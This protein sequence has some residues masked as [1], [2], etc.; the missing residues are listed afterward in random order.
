[1][2]TIGRGPGFNPGWRRLLSALSSRPRRLYAV[3][4]GCDPH[5]QTPNPLEAL[6]LQPHTSNPIARG[7]LPCAWDATLTP[8]PQLQPFNRTP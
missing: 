8:K 4:G 3:R 2:A 6:N 7:C 5:P 1:M